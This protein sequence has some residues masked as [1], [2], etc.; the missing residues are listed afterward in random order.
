MSVNQ[1][2]G[3]SIAEVLL[4]NS[5]IVT[6]LAQLRFPTA[7]SLTTLSGIADFQSALR[8]T[9]PVM[10]HEDQTMAKLSPDGRI[11]QGQGQQVW[12]FTAVD[13]GWGVALTP[14]WVAIDTTQY[15]TRSDFIERW[16]VVLDALAQ[17]DSA[18]VVFDRLGIRYVDRLVGE[19]ATTLLSQ[20]VNPAILGAI[21]IEDGMGDNVELVGTI[22]QAHFKLDGP[23]LIA[24]WGR[25]PANG[26]VVP[27][28]PSVSETSWFLDIDVFTDTELQRFDVDEVTAASDRSAL[29]A[30]HFFRWAMNEDF[31]LRR[32]GIS[33]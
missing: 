18:P 27:G 23:Q 28:V 3:T 17:L 10:R 25:V 4:Q 24:R 9:Y 20:Q 14:D 6:V 29:H 13:D 1:F 33:K 22:T 16:R 12:R 32:G 26:A 8:D 21:T 5:P 19:E 2:S 31:I 7:A 15:T 30:Y 11:L